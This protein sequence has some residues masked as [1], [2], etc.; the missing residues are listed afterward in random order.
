MAGSIADADQQPRSMK[1]GQFLD[2]PR[3]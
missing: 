2:H 3:D 1:S